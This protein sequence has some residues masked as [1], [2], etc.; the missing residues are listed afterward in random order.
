M[1]LQGRNP[2][3]M[4]RQIW[5]I[6]LGL[7]VLTGMVLG[8]S[9]SQAQPSAAFRQLS[10]RNGLPTSMIHC[11]AQD[12]TGFIWLGTYTGLYRYDGYEARPYKNDASRPML[13]P[14]GEVPAL[15][16]DQQGS[17]WIGTQEGL[18][19]MTLA[20]GAV[21]HYP[22]YG[23]D[24]QRINSLCLTRDGRL[25]A[26]TIRGLAVYDA[27]SDTMTVVCDRHATGDVPQP[28]STNIQELIELPSGDV[29]IGTLGKGVY[30]YA[31]QQHRF[32]HYDGTAH[33]DTVY[34]LCSDGGDRVWMGTSSGICEATLDRQGNIGDHRHLPHSDDAF[35]LRWNGR[36]S[37]LLAGTRHGLLAYRRDA[38]SGVMVLPDDVYVRHL[39]Q[40]RDRLLWVSTAGG[41]LFVETRPTVT[42]SVVGNQSTTALG[43]DHE[44]RMWHSH[45]L[46]TLCGNQ[47]VTD[48][49][50]VMSITRSRAGRCLLLS[51]WNEGFYTA[52]EGHLDRVFTPQNS[53]LMVH[54]SVSKV[55][56][57]RHGHWWVA[58]DRGLGVRYADGREV[59][60]A[61]IAGADTLLK[62]SIEDLVE[63]KDGTL[64]LLLRNRGM[65]HLSG[66]LNRPDGIV[67]KAYQAD[68]GLLPVNTVFCSCLSADGTLW[69]GTDGGGLCRYDR[70][71]DRF[72]SLHE[73]WHL[74]GDMVMSMENDD[75][76]CL[77]MGT[78][79]GLACLQ[80]GR[81]DEQQLRVY[82]TLDG[83]PDN[84]FTPRA[85]DSYGGRLYFGTTQ[86][87][88][89]FRPRQPQQ[90]PLVRHQVGIVGLR[91][92]GEPVACPP[93]GVVDMITVP[94]TASVFAVSFASLTYSGQQKYV[95]S[96][97]LK[98][99]DSRWHDASDNRWARYAHLSPGRYTLEV[100]AT[101]GYGNWSDVRSI[102]VTIEP[103]LWRTWWAYLIY[104][105]VGAVFVYLL[106]RE[107]RSRMMTR[108][109][110]QMQLGDDGQSQVVVKHINENE[111]GNENGNG[112]GNKNEDE[113]GNEN[114]SGKVKQKGRGMLAI[115]IRDLNFTDADEEFLRQAVERVSSHLSD[116][117]YGPQQLCDDMALSRTTL[118]RRLKTLTGMNAS[119]FISEL[120]LK[121]ACR[122]IDQNR[123]K[124]IRI[125]DLAY[126]LG[127]NDPKYFSLLFRKKYGLSP[128]DYMERQAHE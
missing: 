92:D 66:E 104:I 113:D 94:G 83:L 57:D 31:P 61:A 121:A 6:L 87:A 20:T 52:S 81:G 70:E 120:R 80:V 49:K 89:V 47:T 125:S 23:A 62:Q 51:V 68:N 101:D 19:R 60:F 91:I 22:L 106:V 103:P 8:V 115:E 74:P 63:D 17:L 12:E 10:T 124:S 88:V 105:V 27:A 55:L 86:G 97:R 76:G 29:L 65:V 96:Y 13:M 128:T 1:H 9:A 41:G 82:T 26:G 36:D 37:T 3:N 43:V 42:F 108:N 21:K 2:K 11:V 28:R 119:Q 45:Y 18:C 126:E 95:Y 122:F 102:S 71:R 114:G 79:A 99:V 16:A 7:A 118:F 40:D 93:S 34:S 38:P 77:W 33:T 127:F 111:N 98:G 32:Y 73:R 110:L 54:G 44:G 59:C 75:Y 58:T 72:E 35:A 123:D 109:R 84:Y 14:V 24:K 85:S 50:R 112:N 90:S 56:E 48:E 64:W 25:Y 46:T 5:K 53:Q 107:V 4:K 78:N 100:R 116:S 15:L 39:F 117:D 69:V 67:C 30:R